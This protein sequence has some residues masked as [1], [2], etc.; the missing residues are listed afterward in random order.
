MPLEEELSAWE[1]WLLQYGEWLST[2]IIAAIPSVLLSETPIPDFPQASLVYSALPLLEPRASG[3]KQNFVCWPFKRLS[4]SLAISLWQKKTFF[5]SQLDVIWVSFWLWFCGLGSPAR[6][7]D[8]TLLRGTPSY[9]NIPPELQLPPMIAQ[10][11]VSRLLH[12]L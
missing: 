4:A 11:A 7:L 10:P 5:F 8:P 2:V 1:R 6:G 3:Y 12:I 9:W